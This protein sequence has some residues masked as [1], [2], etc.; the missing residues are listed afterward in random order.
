MWLFPFLS[1]DKFASLFAQ[2]DGINSGVSPNQAND[3]PF[4]VKQAIFGSC[5]KHYTFGLANCSQPELVLHFS[6]VRVGT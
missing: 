1:R 4:N 2:L 5:G 3:S 6:E